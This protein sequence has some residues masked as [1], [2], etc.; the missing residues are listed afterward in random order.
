MKNISD[1][2]CTEIKTQILGLVT[3][4][5]NSAVYETIWKNIVDR[6]KPQVTIW[7]MRI[8]FSIPKATNTHTQVV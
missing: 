7:R 5:E 4:F 1:K 3:F 8:T 2:S 6:G